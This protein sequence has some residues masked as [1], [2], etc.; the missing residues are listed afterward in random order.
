MKY[1]TAEK[2]STQFFFRVHM[3]IT[4]PQTPDNVREYSWG[5]TPP[6][7]QTETQYLDNIKREIGLLVADELNRMNTPTPAP[8]PLAGF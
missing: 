1:L 6:T 5:L 4:K 3:D 7:G 8:T 2:Q